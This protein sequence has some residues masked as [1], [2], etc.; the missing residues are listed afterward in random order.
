MA[1]IQP[2]RVP[3]DGRTFRVT[4]ANMAN[5]DTGAPVS[6]PGAADVTIQV[7]EAGAFGVGGTV[8]IEGCLQAIPVTYF[9]LKDPQGNAMTYTQEDAEMVSQVTTHI[10]PR[11]SGGDGNTDLTV[12]ALFRSTMR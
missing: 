5:G 3:A 1:V 9:A 11:I 8:A 4:W 6:R 2:S 10:R 7:I 12:I